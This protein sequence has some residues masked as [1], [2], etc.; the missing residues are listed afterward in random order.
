M[1]STGSI[2]RSESKKTESVTS[3]NIN[4]YITPNGNL[5]SNNLYLGDIASSANNL[6]KFTT[7]DKP[8]ISSQPKATVPQNMI[9]LEVKDEKFLFSDN[10]R[11]F[12]G[13]F[14]G[15]ELLK[16][17]ICKSVPSFLSNVNSSNSK[18]IIEKYIC[19][20]ETEK[21]SNSFKY[22]IINH[23][24]SPFTG[25]VEMLVKL[26][27][28]IDEFEKT[29]LNNELSLLPEHYADKAKKTYYSFILV[30]LNHILK[31]I[32]ILS[33]IIKNNGDKTLYDKLLRYSISITYKISTITKTQITE[34]LNLLDKFLSEKNKLHNI[35][36]ILSE[37]IEEL[38]ETLT[39]QDIK[40]SRLVRESRDG[41]NKHNIGLHSS[42]T[43]EGNIASS[44]SNINNMTDAVSE[45]TTLTDILNNRHRTKSHYSETST[46]DSD[47]NIRNSVLNTA[48][49]EMFKTP[50]NNNTSKISE[51]SYLMSHDLLDTNNIIDI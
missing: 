44:S 6:H 22:N 46:F 49:S 51:F 48:T 40:I 36:Q 29:K 25:H 4:D 30:L 12:L 47:K 23:L 43:S 17:I 2:A 32:S 50:T 14:N 5:V 3:N 21:T 20:V 34:K 1:L 45:S 42:T 41:C 37:R 38:E 9:M 16:Y 19:T 11:V 33:D 26:Y 35:Q 39:E 13:S 18:E 27:K 10:N 15:E 8:Q 28:Q 7:E 24:D 31:I